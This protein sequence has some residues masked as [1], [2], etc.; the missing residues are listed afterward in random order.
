MG[1]LLKMLPQVDPKS[2][3]SLLS[4]L[5]GI[6]GSRK[7][8]SGDILWDEWYE[9]FRRNIGHLPHWQAVFCRRWAAP[10]LGCL[11]PTK[12]KWTPCDFSWQPAARSSRQFVWIR[13]FTLGLS[14]ASNSVILFSNHGDGTAKRLEC[15][16]LAA[17]NLF[18][19]GL[20]VALFVDLFAY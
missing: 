1:E 11:L 10:L 15:V 14:Q 19:V 8:S 4:F 7:V 16:K 6:I 5:G 9:F 18:S 13:S 12:S 3:Q 2:R 20:S 17:S